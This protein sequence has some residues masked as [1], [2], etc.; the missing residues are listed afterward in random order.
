M[1]WTASRPMTSIALDYFSCHSS[2]NFTLV[3]STPTR[4]ISDYD[5]RRFPW[6][7]NLSWFCRKQILK[8]HMVRFITI[9]LIFMDAKFL[10]LFLTYV[11]NE[12]SV[13]KILAQCLR[14]I[15]LMIM[16]EAWGSCWS[17]CITVRRLLLLHTHVIL[18]PSCALRPWDVTIHI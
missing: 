12:T 8:M 6:I 2:T 9:L 10:S 17:H 1:T 5:I 14:E 7:P 4:R 11:T 15:E 16:W 13:K 18:Q 3:F